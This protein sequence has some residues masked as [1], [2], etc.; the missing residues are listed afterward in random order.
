MDVSY[1]QVLAFPC[2]QFGS[3][4]PGTCAE[5]KKFASTMYDADFPIFDKVCS[6]LAS[7]SC[8]NDQYPA[9]DACRHR[10]CCVRKLYFIRQPM[11]LDAAVQVDV[12]GPNAS[13]V[14]QFLKQHTPADMGGSADIDW[15]FAK[16]VVCLS[17]LSVAELVHSASAAHNVHQVREGPLHCQQHVVSALL[18]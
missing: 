14:F 13:P 10:R 8:A 6:W 2:N 3:Q 16:W 15:N 4:E 12:N 7:R 17:T 1:A 9:V 11:M 5:V 18:C